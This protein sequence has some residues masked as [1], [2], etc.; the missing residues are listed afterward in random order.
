MCRIN[1]LVCVANFLPDFAKPYE[2]RLEHTLK[3]FTSKQVTQLAVIPEHKIFLAL[4]SEYQTFITCKIM[5][6]QKH[7]HVHVHLCYQLEMIRDLAN[8]PVIDQAYLLLSADT[9]SQYDIF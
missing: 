3:R 7:I 1:I 6:E 2:A 8:N 4:A 9:N 5:D